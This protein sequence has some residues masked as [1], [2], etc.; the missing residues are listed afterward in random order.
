MSEL[1]YNPRDFERIAKEICSLVT[2]DID[3][4]GIFYRVFFRCKSEK[5]LRT[6]LNTINNDMSIKYDGVNKRIRDLIGLRVNLYFVDDLETLYNYYKK[7]FIFVEETI[8]RNLETEFKPTR[9][10]LIFRI[11]P[12][13]KKEFYDNLNNNERIDDCFEL[14]LRTILSEGWHEVDHDLR[15][16]C[17]N[18]WQD[19]YDLS[20][21]FNG[22]LASLE[23][24]EWTT[25][26]IFEQLSHVHYKNKNWVAM[27]RNKLRLRLQD[28][29]LNNNLE[30][31]FNKENEIAKS[32]FR[33]E[34][35]QL[36]K[37]LLEKRIVLPYTL[38]NLIFIANKL[39][40]KNDDILKLTPEL[41][42][43]EINED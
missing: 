13:H 33:I 9:I 24:S 12:K 10:N 19:Q 41:V 34:R 30:T 43:N 18:D 22:I 26:K 36:I 29:T 4:I 32:Y 31:I 11:P 15:Y 14:Q 21:T 25:S 17:K 5:S 2:E 37:L 1:N 7:K 6:K 38:N 3:S 27:F 35:C 28:Y 16:K 20:R 40:I 23:T 8:D 42:L 39:I